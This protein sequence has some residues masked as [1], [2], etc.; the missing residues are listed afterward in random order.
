MYGNGLFLFFAAVDAAELGN[1]RVFRTHRA[2]V[3]IAVGGNGHVAVHARAVEGLA[4]VGAHP[5]MVRR[6]GQ[7]DRAGHSG[8]GFGIVPGAGKGD[9]VRRAADIAREGADAGVVL[10]HNTGILPRAADLGKGLARAAG[11]ADG[12]V[13]RVVRGQHGALRFY[14]GEVFKHNGEALA[15]L[16][17]H[18]SVHRDPL[19]AGCRAGLRIFQRARL[20]GSGVRREAGVD[21]KG[22][23]AGDLLAGGHIGEVFARR[24]GK[25]TARRGAGKVRR[26]QKA[27]VGVYVLPVVQRSRFVHH[28]VV[29]VGVVVREPEVAA[30]AEIGAPGVLDQPRA[31]VRRAVPLLK[32]LAGEGIVPA[33]QGDG[34]VRGA[35]ACG[36]VIGV[37]RA[38]RVPVGRVVGGAVVIADLHRAVFGD[39]AFDRL[40]LRGEGED[41]GDGVIAVEPVG[42]G[43]GIGKQLDEILLAEAFIQTV[44]A[45]QRGARVVVYR[46]SDV[47]VVA[48]AVHHIHQVVVNKPVV[49]G[50]GNALAVAVKA[51]P[52]HL[53]FGDV[54]LIRGGD[55]L[56]DSVGLHCSG[57]RVRPAGAADLAFN[58]RDV[59]ER[60]GVPGRGE[61]LSL[62]GVRLIGH[63]GLLFGRNVAAVG[64]YPAGGQQAVNAGLPLHAVHACAVGGRVRDAGKMFVFGQQLLQ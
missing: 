38:A 1:A 7:G 59:A 61:A 47:T 45:F 10:S 52:Y 40:R 50:I 62:P 19:F 17:V 49:A 14:A 18:V 13:K 41:A 30:V 3:G 20:R 42:I 55:A 21:L 26:G 48:A 29:D 5:C 2:S 53:V 28:N 9:R 22:V 27:V 8:D 58:G 44:A 43:E 23:A 63:K 24:C 31:V 64:I 39:G 12:L 60:T 33:H 35:R 6:F 51:E 34:V 16:Q 36:I 32:V 57:G 4:V 25:D 46:V 15:R 56:F 37:R 54:D 11:E